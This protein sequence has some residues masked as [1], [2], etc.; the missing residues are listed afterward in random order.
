MMTLLRRLALPLLATASATLLVGGLFGCAGVVAV[1]RGSSDYRVEQPT[2]LSLGALSSYHRG[3]PATAEQALRTFGEPDEIIELGPERERWRYR[4]GLRFHGV[5][6]LLI[7]VPVPLLV[8]TGVHHAY[9]ELEQ[10]TVVQ[11]HGS[12]NADLAR[13]GCLIGPLARL[14]GGAGCFARWG[15]APHTARL[16]S[17]ELWLGPPPTLRRAPIDPPR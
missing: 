2:L 13:I 15:M 7:V 5:A 3:V 12:Q 17:G 10:S 16:G 8:P 14:S 4:T 9:V 11:V 1:V 6:L